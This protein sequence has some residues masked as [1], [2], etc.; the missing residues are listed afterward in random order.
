MNF[1]I[2]A[3]AAAFC[4]SQS[5]AIIGLGFHYAPN[6]GTEL[7]STTEKEVLSLDSEARNLGNV[8]YAHGSFS[9]MQGF[10]LKLWIDILPIIDV[11]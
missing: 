11:E 9:D 8:K 2:I 5:F 3:A 1:K 6:I 4:V 10:G 7:K